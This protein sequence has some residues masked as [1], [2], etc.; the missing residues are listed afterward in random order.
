MSTDDDNNE[1]RESAVDAFVQATLRRIR[2]EYL[3]M[4]GMRLT[5]QQV[6]RLFGIERPLCKAVLDALVDT[7]FLCVNANGTY[8]RL[9]DGMPRLHPAKADLRIQKRVTPAA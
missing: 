2:A 8:A 5:V 9:T 1:E 6:E 7:D 3:E 4:P